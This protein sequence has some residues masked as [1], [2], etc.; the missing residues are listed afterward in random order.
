MTMAQHDLMDQ[1][2]GAAAHPLEQL[3][4]LV[5]GLQDLVGM[6]AHSL[7]STELGEGIGLV[8][9]ATRRLAHIESSLVGAV[10]AS[11][12]WSL[13]GHRT[14]STWLRSQTAASKAATA[15]TVRN[16]RGLRHHLPHAAKALAAGRIGADHV[17]VLTKHVLSN[18]RLVDLVA[19]PEIETMLVTYAEQHDAS[20][21][22]II[23]RRW[24]TQADPAAAD[25]AWQDPTRREHLAISPTLG[26][27]HLVGWL[28]EASG[29]VVRTAMDA[30][31]ET[32]R[33]AGDGLTIAER[34]AGALVTASHK[35]LT[36]GSVTP[37]ARI[38][39]H[40][41]ITATIQT[42][43]ALID[44]SEHP[45]TGPDASNGDD[46]C[47]GDTHGGATSGPG[48][49]CFGTGGP[50]S[51]SG[52][53]GHCS[54]GHGGPESGHGGADS[55]PE[56]PAL[57]DLSTWTPGDDHRIGTGLDYQVL[58]GVEPATFSDRTPLSPKMLA[59]YL[60]DSEWARVIFGPESTVLDVGRAQRIHPANMVRAV[61]ARDQHCQFPGC[62]SP[63]EYGEIHHAL[64]WFKN[65]GPTDIEHGILL[66]YH[67]HT[68]V[69]KR[70]ITIASVGGEWIFTRPNGDH[71]TA[72][73]SQAWPPNAPPNA[74]P[75]EN[76][77]GQD[78]PGDSSAHND[79]SD[80]SNLP[81]ED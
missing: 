75:N 30:I 11:G 77:L 3:R 50:F 13:G 7:S 46:T 31:A 63:P 12:T 38:R 67:H 69:H 23:V 8:E 80:G 59:R 19:D 58:Q 45:L 35:M 34:R 21:F 18:P 68:Y 9:Q 43:K 56:Q 73:A 27:W 78:D 29:Q 22:D 61:I 41:T 48:G 54:S 49:N 15:V 60:C 51:E 20:N 36:D 47:G 74:S 62:Q 40:I 65:T 2:P 33:Q 53:P 57:P 72:R 32:Q 64:Q 10:E 44:A 25:R 39:P 28:D 24:A 55:A 81:P 1:R 6:D 79:V 42:I 5:Q 14:L 37:N 76:P 52:G 70:D 4:D 71:I 26:G 17:S 16:S 66:C